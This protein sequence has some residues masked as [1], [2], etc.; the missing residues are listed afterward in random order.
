VI[1]DDVLVGR[2]RWQDAFVHVT[3]MI[4]NETLGITVIILGLFDGV[5][6]LLGENE[7]VILTHHLVADASLHA[8]AN[9]I[10]SLCILCM[11]ENEKEEL[12]KNDAGRP[13]C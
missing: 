13:C 7:G 9:A 10:R 12:R 5:G 8:L 1:A 3:L 4:L 6:G 2:Q 11:L